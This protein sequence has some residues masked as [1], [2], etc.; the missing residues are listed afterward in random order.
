M[1]RKK[2]IRLENLKR[3]LDEYYKAE[4]RILRSQSYAAGSQ[5]LTRTSLASVQAEIKELEEEIAV[6]ESRGTIKRR[7]VRVIPFS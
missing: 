4:S 7:S 1:E 5:Q 6:L 3:R 2:D